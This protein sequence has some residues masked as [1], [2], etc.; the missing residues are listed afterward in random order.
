MVP[1]KLRNAVQLGVDLQTNAF[2]GELLYGLDRNKK[3]WRLCLTSIKG[4][5][6]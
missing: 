3:I 4:Q 6:I 1:D 5:K 2:E